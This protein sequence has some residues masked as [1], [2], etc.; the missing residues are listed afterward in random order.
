MTTYV[1]VVF[2]WPAPPTWRYWRVCI[3]CAC[4]FV[5]TTCG[6]SVV[7]GHSLHSHTDIQVHIQCTSVLAAYLCTSIYICIYVS[8]MC[9]T[10]SAQQHLHRRPQQQQQRHTFD[11]IGLAKLFHRN[12]C[13]GIIWAPIF[14]ITLLTICT[15]SCMCFV[16]YETPSPETWKKKNDH[17]PNERK[18]VR[19]WDHFNC[20]RVAG[21]YLFFVRASYECSC[22]CVLYDRRWFRRCPVDDYLLLFA[23]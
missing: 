7:F 23:E 14:H 3:C 19:N 13:D 12:R 15:W 1:V 17:P 9:R 21:A 10:C 8:I 11:H 16:C 2:R 20:V 18:R 5:H 22:M 6:L 4:A